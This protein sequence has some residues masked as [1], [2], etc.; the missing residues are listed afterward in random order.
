MFRKFLEK[1]QSSDDQTKKRWMVGSTTV[2]IAIVIYV[3]IGYFNNLIFTLS[4]PQ[5]SPLQ[6]TEGFSFLETAKN[7]AAAVFDTAKSLVE[8]VLSRPGEY[9]IK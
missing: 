9:I 7:A 8:N 6:K 1:L 2:I 5:E 3:W 4:S